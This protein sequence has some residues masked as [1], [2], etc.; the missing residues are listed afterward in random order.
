MEIKQIPCLDSNYAYLLHDP[1]SGETAAVD[2]PDAEVILRGLAESG[3]RLTS[4]LNTHHHADHTGGNPR[5]KRETGCV[6]HGPRGEAARIPGLDVPLAEGD[7]VR[8]GEAQARVLEVPGHTGGHIA[9]HF[10]DEGVAFVGDTLFSLGC[11]RLF[12]GT[13][14]QMWNSLGKL[15]ALPDATL[16]YCAHEYTQANA[17]FALSIEPG[18][19]HLRK[20][21]EEVEALRAAGKPTVPSRL[22]AEKRANPFLRAGEAG[23]AAALDMTGAAAVE[24]FAE[25]RRRKDCFPA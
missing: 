13:P 23:I 9:Y 7:S 6:I 14:A 4:I 12:E 3:W 2:T 15:M 22:D 24:I 11:G 16:L 19:E 17:R 1:V 25:L 21:N 18:N 10:A 5:L 20:R 8:V